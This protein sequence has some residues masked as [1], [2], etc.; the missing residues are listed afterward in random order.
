MVRDDMASSK[1]YRILEIFELGRIQL[2]KCRTVH[3]EPNPH[4][5]QKIGVP[6][7]EVK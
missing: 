4:P 6:V 1:F 5:C 7:V 2:V 3:K